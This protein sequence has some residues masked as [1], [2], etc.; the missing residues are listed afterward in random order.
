MLVHRLRRWPSIEPTI[1]QCFVFAGIYTY[2]ELGL[3]LSTQSVGRL[4]SDTT[5]P[6]TA[7]LGGLPHSKLIPSPSLRIICVGHMSFWNVMFR[8]KVDGRE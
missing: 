4:Y 5:S 7:W 3:F 1:A 8:P 6:E 2:I